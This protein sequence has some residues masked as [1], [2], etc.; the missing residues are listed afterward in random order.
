[1]VGPILGG[2]LNTAF[3][4]AYCYYILSGFLAMAALF[5]V[6]V[7]P[8]SINFSTSEPEEGMDKE[9]KLLAE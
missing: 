5:N 3:G 9:E 6:L 4:Y 8:N 7:M 2:S 1:M